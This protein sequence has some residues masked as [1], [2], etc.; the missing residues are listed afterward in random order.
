MGLIVNHHVPSCI[1]F[2]RQRDKAG[3]RGIDGDC[4]VRTET[5][6]SDLRLCEGALAPDLILPVHGMQCCGSEHMVD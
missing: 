6:P 5:P 4:G 1:I 2:R 3:T